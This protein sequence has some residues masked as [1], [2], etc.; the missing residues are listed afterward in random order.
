MKKLGKYVT[1][2]SHEDGDVF[3]Q[4]TAAV[5]SEMESILICSERIPSQ[6]AHEKATKQLEES[7]IDN[8][9]QLDGAHAWNE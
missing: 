9:V 4:Y 6:E 1:V 7:T 8:P 3:K 2:C 5:L